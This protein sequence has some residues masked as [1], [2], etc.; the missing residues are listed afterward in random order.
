LYKSVSKLLEFTVYNINKV[1]LISN[2]GSASVRVLLVKSWGLDYFVMILSIRL[3]NVGDI[4]F[5][6]IVRLNDDSKWAFGAGFIRSSVPVAW[7]ALQVTWWR[8]VV[9]F[10]VSGQWISQ[11]LER[12]LCLMLF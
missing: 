2:F 4:V 11:V 9:K 3:L 7:Y 5:T 8:K 10:L 1:G 6:L 12:Q